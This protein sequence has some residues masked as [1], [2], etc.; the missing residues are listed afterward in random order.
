MTAYLSSTS[1]SSQYHRSGTNG[2]EDITNRLQNPGA[3]IPLQRYPQGLVSVDEIL[4]VMIGLAAYL[5][6][7]EYAGHSFLTRQSSHV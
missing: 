5:W 6:K 3:T 7:M 1:I 4:L 2:P